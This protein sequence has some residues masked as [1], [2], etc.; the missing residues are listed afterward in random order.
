MLLTLF[1]VQHHRPE[2]RGVLPRAIRPRLQQAAPLAPLTAS[3]PG[4][5]ALKTRGW[6]DYASINQKKRKKKKN[7][8]KMNCRLHGFPPFSP[9]PPVSLPP[10]NKNSH[11]RNT[12]Q[13]AARSPYPDWSATQINRDQTALVALDKFHANGKRRRRGRGKKNRQNNEKRYKSSVALSVKCAHADGSDAQ[14]VRLS[15]P[16]ALNTLSFSLS[17]APKRQ[18]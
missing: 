6:Q 5:M 9:F 14:T 10:I 17:F 11:A 7:P 18:L 2:E 12:V 1:L 16:L 4:K 8:G 13:Y 15:S 3:P